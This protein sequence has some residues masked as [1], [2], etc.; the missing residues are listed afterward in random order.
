MNMSKHTPGP[1]EADD[2]QKQVGEGRPLFE[3]SSKDGIR[4]PL[5]EIEISAYDDFGHV[6]IAVVDDEISAWV[7][8]ARIIAAAPDMLDELKS[9]LSVMEGKGIAPKRQETIRQVI[10]KATS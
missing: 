1:W 10:D 2:P 9:I 5:M 6:T 8:N 4:R 3:I 7:A